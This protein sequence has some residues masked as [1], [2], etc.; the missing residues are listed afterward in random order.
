LSI[1]KNGDRLWFVESKNKGRIVA[2]ATF[3]RTTERILGPLIPLT[4]TNEELGW[5]KDG[6]WDTE[7]NYTDLYDLT[8][9][10]LN[11]E[12]KGAVGIRPYTEKC[13]INLPTEYSNILR[14]SKITQSM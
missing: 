13:K 1:A 7:V 11:S 3:T 5:D 9:F 10:N 4:L 2:V 14:Y 12:I 8:G 6:E